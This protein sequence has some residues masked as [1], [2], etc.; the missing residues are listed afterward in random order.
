MVLG[1]QKCPVLGSPDLRGKGC[2]GIL[3]LPPFNISFKAFV[4]AG[5]TYPPREKS[6]SKNNNK[7]TED[8]LKEK[9]CTN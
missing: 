7:T 4:A 9:Q 5:A 3:F 2:L 1:R 8:I 6:E